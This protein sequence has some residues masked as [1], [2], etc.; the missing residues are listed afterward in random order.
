[1]FTTKIRDRAID[2]AETRKKEARENQ[3]IVLRRY[4]LALQ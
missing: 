3:F 1:M 2:G 4:A